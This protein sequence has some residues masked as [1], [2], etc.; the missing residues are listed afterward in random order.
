MLLGTKNVRV[1][2]TLISLA[3]LDQHRSDLITVALERAKMCELLAEAMRIPQKESGYTVGLLSVRDAITQAPME[4]V[5]KS[6]PLE[7]EI[8]DAL[9]QHK[10]P[11]GRI[12]ACTLAYERCDWSALDMLDLEPN[13]INDA[14]MTALAE[15]YRA[16][17]ELLKS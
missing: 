1:W 9:L 15:A 11:L 5:L 4:L 10:G 6:L 8:N 16:S 2:A 13:Q 17:C 12:L 14:Y 7:E 3:N